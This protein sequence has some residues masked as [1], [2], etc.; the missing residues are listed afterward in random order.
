MNWVDYGYVARAHGV[1]GELRVVAF[2]DVVDLGALD[3]LRLARRGE[4]GVPVKDATVFTIASCRDTPNGW[5]VAFKGLDDRDVAESFKGA[6]VQL[7]TNDL[8]PLKG[9]EYYLYELVGAEVRVESG[10]CVGVVKRLLDNRG[11]VLMELQVGEETRLLP[12]V[13]EFV[14]RFDREARVLSVSLLPGLWADEDGA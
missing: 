3:S 10:E 11:Q 12:H 4:A 2:D 1:R 5:L 13:P 8:P 14:G 6:T 9:T 7:S